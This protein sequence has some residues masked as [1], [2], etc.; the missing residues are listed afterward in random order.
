MKPLMDSRN[1]DSSRPDDED[2]GVQMA[3]STR[4][5]PASGKSNTTLGATA[6]PPNHPKASFLPDPDALMIVDDLDVQKKADSSTVEESEQAARQ[7]YRE[8][9]ISIPASVRGSFT[10]AACAKQVLHLEFFRLGTGIRLFFLLTLFLPVVGYINRAPYSVFFISI[11][12][13]VVGYFAFLHGLTRGILIIYIHRVQQKVLPVATVFRDFFLF[14]SIP[15]SI[16]MLSLSLVA[17]VGIVPLL[18]KPDSSTVDVPRNLLIPALVSYGL[19]IF[20]S[21][22]SLFSFRSSTLAYSTR[23]D[24]GLALCIDDRVTYF[25]RRTTFADLLLSSV[26][27]QDKELIVD[28][29]NRSFVNI[30]LAPVE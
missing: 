16:L 3:P 25:R 19:A 24:D 20:L 10:T 14:F 11:I 1:Q 7:P 4:V 18:G 23:K 9:Y 12:Y 15:C 27:W 17:V 22:L 8:P 6:I 21:V 30:A 13:V 28:E 2:N 29:A 26:K 5:R